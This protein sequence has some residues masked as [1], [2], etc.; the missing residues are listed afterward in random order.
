LESRLDE[1]HR[2]LGAKPVPKLPVFSDE[3]IREFLRQQSLHF[4]GILVSDPELARQEIQKH[5]TKLVLTP[6]DT[7][8]GRRLE[9]TGD[10]ALFVGDDVMENSSFGGN[11]SALHL[12][13]EP[14]RG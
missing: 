14:N 12:P 10:V 8:E 9:V 11:C 2:L 5:I 7:P 4:C 6:K 13:A 3:Q 1:I